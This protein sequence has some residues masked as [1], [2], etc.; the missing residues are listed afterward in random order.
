[1]A[2]HQSKHRECLN[3]DV[4]IVTETVNSD[5]VKKEDMKHVHTKQNN[6]HNRGFSQWLVGHNDIMFLLWEMKYIL[7]QKYFIVSV[8]QDSH[9][10][11]LYRPLSIN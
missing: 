1:M 4:G 9:V 5:C 8:Q 6:N 7:M 3:S 2:G 11:T 10:R